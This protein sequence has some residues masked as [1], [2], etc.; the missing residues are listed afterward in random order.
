[1]LAQSGATSR[2][3]DAAAALDLGKGWVAQA[4]YRR[5]STQAEGSGG[6]AAG[7]RF[8]SDAWSFDVS[9]NGT[10]APGDSF[11]V[12]VAQP[13]RVRS[14]GLDLRVPVGWNRVL[15]EAEFEQRLFALSPSGRE[16]DVEAAYMLS[17]AEGAGYLGAHG[18]LRRQPGHIAD[19]R[20]DYGAALRAGLRF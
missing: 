20:S 8:E 4:T 6:L 12:R 9:R 14:G 1:M 13:L 18:F 7:G 15:G 2:F 17:L 16:I 10:L 19:A 3:V 11:S 5:G